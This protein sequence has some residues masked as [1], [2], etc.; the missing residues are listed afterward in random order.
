MMT[1]VD[2]LYDCRLELAEGPVW[3][4]RAGQLIWVD[5][6]DGAVYQGDLHADAPAQRT[7]VGTHVGAALPSTLAGE[8]LLCVREGFARRNL[9]TGESEPVA[10]PLADRPLSRFNDAKVG[11]DGRAF[12]GTMPYRAR[13][14]PAALYRL[15]PGPHARPVI[16]GLTLSNG[17]GWSPDGHRMYLIDS[18]T[19]TVL[20]CDYDVTDGTLGAVRPLI[21][22]DLPDGSMPDGMCID[23][24]GC[25]WIAI[26]GSG[27]LRRYSPDGQL[28]RQ[29]TLPVSQPT[30]VCF[31]GARGDTLIITSASYG[32][33]PHALA[34]EPHAGSLFAFDPGVTGRPA[35]LWKPELIGL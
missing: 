16:D 27:E 3:D 35:T 23:D 31:A 14:E 5:I 8:M 29:M 2:V 19:A 11:P 34:S 25:L 15:G 32:L 1:S 6:L 4:A 17:L 21:E 20:T 33:A 9:E 26:W 22:F 12:G 18:G 24:A 13:D 10:S 30:S 28:D 7:D